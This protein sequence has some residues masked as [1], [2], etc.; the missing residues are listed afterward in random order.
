MNDNQL[1]ILG[2]NIVDRA[3]NQLGAQKNVSH[4]PP[5][6]RIELLVATLAEIRD[7]AKALYIEIA[8]DDPWE[9]KHGRRN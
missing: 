2:H 6:L 3:E 1:L 4:L 9:D 7:E 8:G 5:M